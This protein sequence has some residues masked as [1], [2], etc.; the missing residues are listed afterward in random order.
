MADRLGFLGC[1]EGYVELQ[2][3]VDCSVS[4]KSHSAVFAFLSRS[5]GKYLYLLH[6]T[7]ERRILCFL[8]FLLCFCDHESELLTASWFL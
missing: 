5:F 8:S 1:G 6:F 7:G 4:L 3:L 2:P